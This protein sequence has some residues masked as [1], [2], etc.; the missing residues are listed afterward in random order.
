[1]KMKKLIEMNLDTPSAIA[2]DWAISIA[3]IAYGLWSG[4]TLWMIAG[5]LGCVASW[6]RPL[7][8]MQSWARRIISRRAAQ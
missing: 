6:Y 1:M 8:K 7:T 3:S 2:F 4:S 5:L